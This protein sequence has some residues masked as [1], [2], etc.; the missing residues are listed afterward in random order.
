[1][2]QTVGVC[3]PCPNPSHTQAGERGLDGEAVQN[4]SGLYQDNL[5]SHGLVS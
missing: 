1:M 5:I 4:A 3:V 2:T